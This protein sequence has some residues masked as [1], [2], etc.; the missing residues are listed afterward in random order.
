MESADLKVLTIAPTF[1]AGDTA[2][3][4][5]A[6]YF[7]CAEQLSRISTFFFSFCSHKPIFLLR[8]TGAKT[9]KQ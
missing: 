6:A 9:L 1:S 7:T 8:I 3:A 2:E 5:H 4:S